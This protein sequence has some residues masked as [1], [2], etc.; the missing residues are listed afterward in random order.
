[1]L[2]SCRPVTGPRLSTCPHGGHGYNFVTRN[3]IPR[4]FLYIGIFFLI[5]CSTAKNARRADVQPSIPG[6]GAC[7]TSIETNGVMGSVRYV[8]G[9]PR[10]ALWDEDGD[11]SPELEVRTTVD[12]AGRPAAET[13]A[14]PD[15]T[16]IETV[17]RT[18]EGDRLVREEGDRFDERGKA[19]VDG[20]TDW[21]RVLEWDGTKL[22]AETLDQRDAEMLPGV[23]GEPEFRVEYRFGEGGALTEA[24]KYRG[25]E[26]VARETLEAPSTGPTE[27]WAIDFGDDGTVD[28]REDRTHDAR[29]RLVEVRTEAFDGI[30]VVRHEF[31]R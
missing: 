7:A 9:D 25:D 14:L 12:D 8:E 3:L 21:V 31:C 2:K 11:G 13:R 18:F 10:R 23:D 6:F 24:V 19:G 5:G 27:R 20:E 4:T 30:R 28:L 26:I 29:G 15:G 17:T 22:V 1:M 16:V